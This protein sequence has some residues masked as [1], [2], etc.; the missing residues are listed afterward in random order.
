MFRLVIL[1]PTGTGRV[2]EDPGVWHPDYPPAKHWYDQMLAWGYNP[3]S[4]KMQ[5]TTLAESGWNKEWVDPAT[6]QPLRSTLRPLPSQVP[7]TPAAAQAPSASPAA[8]MSEQEIKELSE[9]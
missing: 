5:K 9:S 6:G 3:K 2:E 4:V 1:L 7:H 8:Q